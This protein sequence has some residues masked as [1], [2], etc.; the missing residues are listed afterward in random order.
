MQSTQSNGTVWFRAIVMVGFLA[1]IF[2][3]ALSGNAL[4]DAARKQIEKY[5]PRALVASKSAHPEDVK[6]S[7]NPNATSEA[8]LF[9]SAPASKTASAD[10]APRTLAADGSA[11]LIPTPQATGT[12]SAM[13]GNNPSQVVPV[14]FQSP[15][16][17]QLGAATGNLPGAANANSALNSTAANN[18]FSQMQDRLRQLGATYYLL[19]T[20]GNQQQFY[21]F[22]CKMAVGGNTNYTHCFESTGADPMQVMS[23]VLKQVEAWR[24]G[25][26]VVP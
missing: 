16:V 10:A 22:Y 1:V 24:N 9:N 23:D 20:W 21:R 6:T 11:T 19:E 14:D 2:Y 25:G 4:P 7:S 15:E 17:S 8:P 3:V 26:S 18:P 12:P 5:L 13:T